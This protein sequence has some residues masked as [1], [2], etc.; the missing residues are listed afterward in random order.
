VNP[1]VS[2][3]LTS[4]LQ[5]GNFANVIAR[6]QKIAPTLNQQGR[7]EASEVIRNLQSGQINLQ[8]NK[9][10]AETEATI[11]AGGGEVPKFFLQGLSQE[12]V[13]AITG[14]NK[15]PEQ[16]PPVNNSVSVT[17][18]GDASKETAQAV[19]KATLDALEYKVNVL[20]DKTGTV[21]PPKAVA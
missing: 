13:D 10:R 9:T 19:A 12:A 18:Q 5:A 14:T 2:D 3:S 8:A 20:I 7:G 11:K 15:I 1:G 21:I 16:K 17:V 6:L 4:E